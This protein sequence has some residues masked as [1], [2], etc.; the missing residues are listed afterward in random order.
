MKLVLSCDGGGIRGVFTARVLVELERI[1]GQPLCRSFDL[2]AGTSTGGILACGLASGIAA[3]DLLDLYVKRGSEIFS[4][5][6]LELGRNI[7]APRYLSGPLESILREVLGDKTLDDARPTLLVTS[8]A[9]ELPASQRALAV[10][11]S[12][13]APYFFKSSVKPNAFLRD[14]ARATSAAP[15]YF[16]PHQFTNLM[17][18]V[19][20]YVDGGVVAN[21]PAMCA[22]AEALRRWPGEQLAV[23]SIGTGNLEEPVPYEHAKRWGLVGWARPILSLMMDGSCDTVTYQLSQILGK[24]HV[25]IDT[26]LGIPEQPWAASDA[27]DDASPDNI[28][29]LC[30]LAERL[31][32]GPDGTAAVARVNDLLR[33]RRLATTS[34]FRDQRL[35]DGMAMRGL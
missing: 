18:E 17:G 13:R 28:A 23:I 2:V 32:S 3:R 21:N 6:I 5:E 34:V 20:A 19:G 15:T 11:G 25:R 35:A 30:G 16:P 10:P 9:I 27:M 4:Q 7:L 1:A 14:V 31:L 12:T 22:F 33:R 8:Y 29:R 24:D 26:S